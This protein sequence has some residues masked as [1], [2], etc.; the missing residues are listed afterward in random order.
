M[1][2]ETPT[3]K[4]GW[5]VVRK[6]MRHGEADVVYWNERLGI[7]IR[8]QCIGEWERTEIADLTEDGVENLR[9]I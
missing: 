5:K 4:P 3:V 9:T 8:G 1:E 7:S 6:E 2:K